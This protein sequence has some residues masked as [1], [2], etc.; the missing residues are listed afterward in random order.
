MTSDRGH[1]GGSL[2]QGMGADLKREMDILA[3]AI[4]VCFLPAC[5]LVLG[6]SSK[7]SV[8]CP[9]S[10]CYR[11]RDTASCVSLLY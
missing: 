2:L 4:K 6:A 11:E 5:L 10:C 8:S 3:R 9:W 7:A 1:D